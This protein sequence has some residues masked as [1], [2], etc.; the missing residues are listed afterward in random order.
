MAQ[1]GVLERSDAVPSRPGPPAASQARSYR[2]LLVA[3][4]VLA[5]GITA[6]GLRAHAMWF[7]ELQAWNIARASHS[8]GDLYTNLRYEG[9]PILWYLPLFALTR[10]TGNPHSMQVLQW[11]IATTTFALVLFRAPFSIPMRVAVIAGY[12]FAFE[13]GV[14]SRSYGLSALLLIA[15]LVFLGRPKPAW[16][17]GGTMLVLLAWT[18]LPGAVLAIAVAATVA[19]MFRTH[20]VFVG[21]V[22]VA[23]AISAYTCIPPSDFSSFAPG[24][25]GSASKFGAGAPVHV[26]SAVAGAW[27]GLIPIPAGVGEWNSNLF[28][29]FPGAVWLEALLAIGLFV[30]IFCALRPYPFARALWS[31]GSL[32]YVGF[33]VIVMLPEQARYAGFPF[34][35]FLACAWLAFSPPARAPRPHDVAGSPREPLVA[36]LLVVLAAQIVAT[37]AIYPVATSEPFSRDES[38]AASVHAA[39]LENAIVSGQDWDGATVGGYLD[40]S[41]YSAVR[42]EWVRYFIHDEREARRFTTLRDR[43]V[44]CDAA[45]IATKRDTQVGVI[46]DHA[47]RGAQLV[48]VSEEARLYRVDAGADATARWC[49]APTTVIA[50]KT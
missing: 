17:W 45:R 46:V 26:A 31:V 9:H 30:L 39:H 4:L 49:S 16:V 48:A 33:F 42:G 36:V 41:V 35:L 20:F 37:V 19:W 10:F 23:A 34:L 50:P 25:G 47:L 1:A 38:L 12:C 32:G 7:D 3:S 14:I 22:L 15:A 28:D 27:R 8:L 2:G 18:S 21:T 11:C 29:G 6:L 40:R 24:L 5:A 44:M 13:Y 43:D